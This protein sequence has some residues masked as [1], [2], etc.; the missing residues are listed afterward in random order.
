MSAPLAIDLFC[1]LG[2]WTEALLAE[3]WDVVGFDIERHDYGSGG[4]PAQIVLQDVRTLHGAQFRDAD[5]IVASPPCQF[6]SRMAMPFKCPWKAEEFERRRN[7]AHDLFWQCWR[8]QHEASEAAGRYIPMIVE[9]VVGAQRWIGEARWHY[10]SFYL[11]GDVPPLMPLAASGVMKLGVT[12]RANGETN[13]HGS[14]KR[15]KDGTKSPGYSWSDYGKPGYKPT[16]FN[17]ENAKRMREAEGT[18]FG[19]SWWNDATNNLIR[20]ASSRSSARKAA[21]AQIAKIPEPLA[22]HIARVFKPRA[23]RPQSIEVHTERCES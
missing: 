18:K 20:K 5:L 21:S 2:G 22:R 10:G 11:W 12:H 6:F 14:A 17:T 4:Y 8:I 7:L 13:F 19:G 15:A 3:G 16:G 1:G 9:N 23:E